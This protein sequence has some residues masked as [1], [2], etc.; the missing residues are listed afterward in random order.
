MW[1]GENVIGCISVK[2][3]SVGGV[4]VSLRPVC[5]VDLGPNPLIPD[6]VLRTNDGRPIKT[7]DGKYLIVGDGE[8]T[9][10]ILTNDGKILLT[11]DGKQL[12]FFNE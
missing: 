10:A 3:T 8:G 11:S 6:G 2:L 9:S 5:A 7:S 4:T 1:S 12:K